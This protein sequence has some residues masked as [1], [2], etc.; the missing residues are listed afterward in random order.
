MLGKW[1][2][3]AWTQSKLS[4]DIRLHCNSGC[5]C[6][7][8]S[9]STVCRALYQKDAHFVCTA[10]CRRICCSFWCGCCSWSCCNS[11]TAALCGTAQCHM[12]TFCLAGRRYPGFFPITQIVYASWHC[13]CV[14]VKKVR[15]VC[16]CR[17]GTYSGTHPMHVSFWALY[18]PLGPPPL[19]GPPPPARHVTCC[20]NIRLLAQWCA[21]M[22]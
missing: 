10:A 9:L 14:L 17:R 15:G 6:S 4:I 20:L 5:L 21:W 19:M 22:W 18:P 16:C 12:P 8:Q 11:V 2:P 7:L 13:R 1:Q 3:H